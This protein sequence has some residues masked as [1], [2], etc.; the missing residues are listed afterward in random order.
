MPAM[1]IVKPGQVFNRIHVDDIVAVLMASV[2]RPR[3]GAIYNLADDEPAPAQDV[4][5]FA[6][7]LAGVP[8]PAEMPIAEARLGPMAASFYAENKRVVN[9][10]IKEEIGVQLR[11][12]TYRDGLCALR[13]A[14]EGPEAA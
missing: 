6:A 10:R 7:S 1:R 13:K 5:A 9:R 3:P 14:G 2:E 4:V 8:P 11:H 12:P